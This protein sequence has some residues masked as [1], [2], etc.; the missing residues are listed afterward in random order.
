MKTPL[1]E[2]VAAADSQGRFLSSTEI[3][4]AFGR[5]RQASASLTAAKALTE[6]ANSLI[7]G[8]AQAV[9]NKYPYTTQMQGANFAADQRGKEKC[10]R[11]IGYY[12][13]MVTYCLVAGGTGPMDEYLIA[14]IDEINRTFDLSP[15]W[16]IEALKYIKANHGLSGDP[17]VEANSY[18]D[19]AI[20]ALS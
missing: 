6:K 17:A 16:Y 5:F 1:T 10:A 15:S 4:V 12:L 13:R 3:Q 7:S 2:A 19:Y 11:D 9:Y 18:I 20:N 8:A 14:G